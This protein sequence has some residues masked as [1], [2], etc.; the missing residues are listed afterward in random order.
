MPA[1]GCRCSL[2]LVHLKRWHCGRHRFRVNVCAPSVLDLHAGNLVPA[3]S[4]T[5]VG[6]WPRRG[7]ARRRAA[8]VGD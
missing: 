6:G 7:A 5:G 8:D 2:S 4:T 3:T 1:G